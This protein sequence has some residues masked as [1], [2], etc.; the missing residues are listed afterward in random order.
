MG[1]VMD[2]LE[3][4]QN[5]QRDSLEKSKA[6]LHAYINARELEAFAF[7]QFHDG[8]QNII[9]GLRSIQAEDQKKMDEWADREAE[10]HK[11]VA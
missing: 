6:V 11:E 5:L 2:I 10:K 8:L 1:N 3:R 4:L 7:E 9:A